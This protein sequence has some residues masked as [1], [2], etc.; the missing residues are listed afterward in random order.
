MTRV[1]SRIFAVQGVSVWEYPELR[2][3]GVCAGVVASGHDL[4]IV[5]RPAD[6]RSVR[7]T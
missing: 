5:L 6:G 3:L 2:Y 7:A 1:F 4:A